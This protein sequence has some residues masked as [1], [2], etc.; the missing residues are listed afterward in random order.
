VIHVYLVAAGSRALRSLLRPRLP[1]F[2]RWPVDRSG[3]EIAEIPLG[4][5]ASFCREHE[6]YLC[7]KRGEILR[8]D[9]RDPGRSWESLGRPLETGARLLF[10]SSRGVLF[11]AAPHAPLH[12][13]Q[14]G[15]ATW[16]VC[17]PVPTWRMDEDDLGHLYAGNYHSGVATLFKSLDGGRSWRPIFVRPACQHVHTVRWDARS[18]SLYV[19]YGDGPLRGQARSAD[20]GESFSLLAEGPE[21]GHTDAAFS[22][23]YV[24]WASDDGS[25]RVYRVHRES[26]TCE[27]LTGRSQFMWWAVAGSRQVYVGTVTSRSQ[28]GERAALLASADQG[29]TWQKLLETPPSER[30]YG[31]GIQADSRRL[32]AGGAVWCSDGE[33]TWRVRR[34]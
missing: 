2:A 17:L 18:G 22:D 9:D 16:E 24:F 29:T 10:A 33:R 14:D 8:A 13:S 28:G 32:S 12:R 21:E 19:A 26:G 34:A 1:D 11:A 31:R 27:A 6:V 3:Y 7:S 25:G 30:R 20:R 5:S 15:G 4:I 23:D